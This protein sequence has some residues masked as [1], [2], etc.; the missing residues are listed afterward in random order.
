MVVAIEHIT[1]IHGLYLIKVVK[2]RGRCNQSRKCGGINNGARAFFSL[3]FRSRAQLLPLFLPFGLGWDLA[4][5]DHERMIGHSDGVSKPST[6]VTQFI[7]RPSKYLFICQ[8]LIILVSM[9]RK[10]IHIVTNKCDNF[11][12]YLYF[13]IIINYIFLIH[14]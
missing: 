4:G 3:V 12:N 8:H 7:S 10:D 2:R 14:R 11:H 1:S 9:L 13:F 5:R 6:F